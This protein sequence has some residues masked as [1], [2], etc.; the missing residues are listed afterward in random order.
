MLSTRMRRILPGSARYRP[1]SDDPGGPGPA[2]GAARRGR[3]AARAP[4]RPARPA[5]TLRRDLPRAARRLGRR[6]GDHVAPAAQARR[7]ARARARGPAYAG[8]DRRRA[9]RGRARAVPQGQARAAHRL[10][11]HRCGD[12]RDQPRADRLLPAE[13]LGPAGGAVVPD[14]GGPAGRLA[15]GR[16]GARRPRGAARRSP[17]LPGLARGARPARPQPRALRVA[18]PRPR[19]GGRPPARARGDLE[20]P[21]AGDVPARRL[22]AR[23]ADAARAGRAARPADAG[24]ARLLR[25]DHRRRRA[26]RPG[27]RGLRRVRGPAHRARGAVGAGR[28]GGSELADRELPRLPERAVGR[29]PRPPRARPGAA[30][31]RGA[32]AR[33]GGRRARGAR[34]AAGRHAG[35]RRRAGRPQRA[36]RHRGRLPP[37]RGAGRR[38]ARGQGH[39][40]RRLADRGGGL[41]RP[42]R[43]GHR[44][45]QQRRPGRGPP[46]AQRVARDRRL[47]QPAREV[48]VAL[49]DRAARRAP[50]GRTA[51]GRGRRGG[52]GRRAAR[53]RAAE[54]R[55]DRRGRRHVHL[56]RRRA[57]HG[58]GGR[59]G[60]A[61]R[62]R[63]RPRRTRRGGGAGASLAARA[64]PVP[65]RDHAAGRVRGRRRAPPVDQARGQRGRR[66]LDER[67]VHPPVP[68]GH[69][70]VTVAELRT[71]DLFDG[72]E[73]EQLET[74]AADFAERRLE[75]GDVLVRMG[76][77][78]VPFSILLEGRVDASVPADGREEVDHQHQAPTWMGAI[79][80][81]SGAEAR[82]TIRAATSCRVGQIDAP[83]FRE[84]VVVTPP[85]FQK[86][87][88]AFGP[89]ISRLESSVVQ[90]EKLA[91]LG[92]MSAG[93][94]HEL[95]NPA[96]AARR[97]AEALADA[98]EILDGAMGSFVEAGVE[99]EDAEVF[100]AL[101]REAVE[102]AA[103]APARDG[104]DA[105]DAEDEIG[106]WLEAHRV[107]DAGGLAQPL[108]PAGD[109]L[110]WVERAG[111]ATEQ[112]SG[113]VKAIKAYTYMDRADLQ[114]VDVH[115]GLDATL[116]ILHHKLKHTSIAVEKRYDR[117]VPFICVY[118]SELNQVWTNL[119]D[120][121][122][123]ALD[124]SGTITITTAP[125]QDTG[126]EVRIADD[127]PG[128]S[129]EEQRRVF[130]PFY[131]TKG[132]GSGTGLGLDTV[133]RIVRERHEGDV[134]LRSRPGATEFTVRLPR[135]P[136]RTAG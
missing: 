87:I 40:L 93:L 37:A 97:S 96:S 75:R 114:E 86:V 107:T 112:M 70:S 31:R 67:A 56:H 34:A 65:A 103:A 92:R 49:P 127:G 129:T 54:R 99:R 39:L 12:R 17:L 20:R 128:I 90:R 35:R 42:D 130:D 28:P 45:R 10:R 98:L 125:W 121:A 68:G 78:E 109:E 131:T 83:R 102:R 69:V 117:F 22:G 1:A 26:G 9:A 122:I 76:E 61:R 27:G 52:R 15:G 126:V 81:L 62:A 132:V 73:Q 33:P 4:R 100:L 60:R 13:A 19:P 136:G 82:V 14:A 18:R 115:E 106:E 2:P 94:A 80:A 124:G 84:L 16:G 110:G 51:P 25:P 64:R 95:N 74:W 32:A 47:P 11:R 72:V 7:D 38:G 41:R 113:L 116:T 43:R 105:A 53:A 36:H 108:A 24:G 50:G 57:V 120:N 133:R 29:R 89:V 6:G 5:Q 59:R 101:K 91:A 30:L 66:G 123:D 119:L 21:P 85:A 55:R 71:I 3:R 8:D 48:D 77:E 104:L 63:L 111:A 118:G 135:A 23:G 79:L 46:G 88:R 58:L 44:R 134:Q